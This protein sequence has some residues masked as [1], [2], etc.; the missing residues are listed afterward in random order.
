MKIQTPPGMRDFYPDDMRRQR[1][2]F[3]HWRAVSEAFGF[4]EYEGPIFEFL[5]LYKLKSGDEIVSELFHFTD[6]GER[7][8]AIR[9]EMTP[10]LARMVAARANALPRPIKWYSIPRMC[11]AERPQRGRLREFFQWNIDI[12]GSESPLADAEIIACA[13]ALFRRLGLTSSDVAMRLNSRPLVD[14]VLGARG[15]DANNM[16][17]AYRLL[18][19]FAKLSAE[20]FAKQWDAEYAAALPAKD[21][22]ALV[23]G[24]D[25]EQVLEI[26][27]DAPA[28][29]QFREFWQYLDAFGVADWCVY[30]L[31]IVRGLAYY[32]GIVF[33][34]HA[35]QHDLRALLGGGRYDNLCGLLDGPQV[36][37]VGLG[38]GDAS[39]LELLREL[40]KLPEDTD[41]LDVFVIDAGA[42]YFPA[43]LELAGKLRDAG[44]RVDFSYKR[45]NVGKQFKQCDKRG[46]RY[47]IVVGAEYAA[48][49]KV[50]VKN[51]ETQE[52][53]DVPVRSLMEQP[54]T[55]LA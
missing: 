30:D 20:D 6:R 9:P 5:D 14:A 35:R 54:R 49:Q 27:G 10:T 26:A 41:A 33:E 47:A 31:K 23:E 43:A 45:Q 25:L 29:G 4:A 17:T 11:R 32:T 42:E 37:G 16:T 15:I 1:R 2:L 18:D 44:L 52:Q 3:D 53:Q 22:R 46:A 55:V 7:E 12:L 38:M 24:A 48:E 51:M 19:R 28:A 21:L 34:A 39:T 36:T 8:F 13:V 50:A 40:G